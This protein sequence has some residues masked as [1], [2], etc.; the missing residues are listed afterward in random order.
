MRGF[1][2]ETGL[3]QRSIMLSTKLRAASMA[4][5]VA[6]L[7][8]NSSDV[9]PSAPADPAR[10]PGATPRDF[11]ASHTNDSVGAPSFVWLSRSDWP[12]FQ[13][14]EIAAKEILTAVAP[15]FK[16]KSSTTATLQ[17]AVIHDSGRGPIIAKFAQRVE[18]VEVF[19]GGLNVVMS[20]G[21]EPVAASGLVA[22]N[23]SRSKAG[24]QSDAPSAL[25]IAHQ[26]LTGQKASFSQLDEQGDYQRFGSSS[27]SFPLAQPAR[28]KRVYFPSKGGL[29]AG[30]FTELL[31]ANGVSHT[32][33]VSATT[34]KILFSNDLVKYDAYSYRVW[35]D[36]TTK[37]PMDGPQ[38]ND[39]VPLVVPARS[40]FKATFVP[41][42]VVTLQNFPFSKNDPWLPA[43]AT[44]TV[45]NNVRA[46]SD[47]GQPNG[48]SPSGGDTI[49]Q[50]TSAATFDYSYDTA[51]TSAGSTPEAVKAAVTQM[52][53]TTNFLHDWFYDSGFDEKSGNH[54]AN[55]LGR[56]G[57]Q[58]DPLLAETQDFS[59]RNNANA[60]TP[61][62]GASPRIQMYLFGGA[63]NAS[64]TVDAPAPNA[65]IKS[66]GTAGQFGKDS[67]DLSGPVVIVSDGGG[68]DAADA[69]ENINS[70][71]AGKIALVHRG[72]CSF[73]QKA[74]K[75]QAAGGVGI[76]IVN[77]A[78]SASPA[79]PPFMGGTAL[80]VT[81]PAVSLNLADGQALESAAAGAVT[82][83][84]KRDPSKDI[85]GALD[86]QIVSHEWGHVLSNRLVGDGS[87]LDT[88]MAGGLGEGWAD[89]LAQLITVR[90]DDA[91][92]ASNANWNGVYPSATYAT[93][94][95]SEFYFGI[96]RV[97]YSTDLTKDPLTFKH[98]AD[99]TPLPATAPISFGEDG[100]SNSE[101]HNTGEVW[102]TMLWEC[103]ASLLRD[104]RFT[105]QQAQDRMKS[106]LVASL[107]LT[108]PS[109]TMLEA[110]DAVLAAAYANDPKDFDLFWKAFA[111][112]G[113]GVG[114]VA[115]PRDALDNNPVK[116]S[117][118][119]GN[120]ASLVSL[121]VK[122]DVITC[123][124][125]GILDEGELGT[126]VVTIRNSGAGTLSETTAKLSSKS[127]KV[128]F[129]DQ[130]IVKFEPFKPF[131]QKTALVKAY[132]DGVADK[133]PLII[134]IAVDDPT[135]VVGGSLAIPLPVQHGV[136]EVADSATTDD[137]ET[138]STAW[139]VTGED[140]FGTSVQWA[141]ILTGTNHSWFIPN[142]GEPADH[143]LTSP[144]FEVT[145]TTFTLAWKHRWAFE[146]SEK[147]MKD[148]D[149]G[150]VEI[151]LDNGKTWVDLSKYAKM[152]YNVTLEDDPETTMVLKG[153]KAYGNE[154]P[155]YPDAWVDSKITVTLP[156]AAATVKLRFRHG[157]DD[158]SASDG[159]EIDDLSVTDLNNKPFWSFV[160]QRDQCDPAGPTAIAPPG[161][162]ATPKQIVRLVG[163]GTHP[164]NLP[165]GF[166]WS[167]LAGPPVFLSGRTTADLAF[168][169]PDTK[170]AVTIKLALRAN[171]G[172][173]LSAPVTVDVLVNPAG[174]FP[175]DDGG[176][177]CKVVSSRSS[178]SSRAL[179]GA[180]LAALAL[181]L[182]RRRRRR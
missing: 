83:T 2:A 136:D 10:A 177:G 81:I 49:A 8:C 42:N 172:A 134:D 30:W 179:W 173:L 94:G 141:R 77:V 5:L 22:T 153:R 178:S 43:A 157:A 164:K 76:I 20:R 120:A 41:S 11:T 159:W 46:Y 107:K 126:I 132:V 162:S 128:S 102:A 64:L 66:V 60:S 98:I 140:Q 101:V 59:G 123:D 53:Y 31:L 21:F 145:D 32:Y 119:V 149:G 176:C 142:A 118:E 131:E 27:S 113:A 47:V 3:C 116:E 45:G 133:E 34:G 129:P 37:L 16:L 44:T 88:N 171:D 71:L 63:T 35:A 50:T 38:G 106:Y 62:D 125:D 154:S 150:V 146:S 130:G 6:F 109:P 36:P 17:A 169:A 108:P 56:G 92:V 163:T 144:A 82:I 111:K 110:R 19:R 7:G 127:P 18:G 84:M 95:D 72:N 160:P 80:D 175:G 12:K 97:P 78:T 9:A 57:K 148:F 89:F 147:D 143:Q 155:G 100:S 67:F 99:G 105:F 1:T 182:V 54:Q 161:Q 139:V 29:E 167:Q 51:S 85:D 170:Q 137:V 181:V 158:N 39:A 152:D 112:R 180:G 65:G 174:A 4:A 114:A 55:N 48:Y 168:E 70:S 93:G 73:V 52:F 25:A 151:T 124:R 33:V 90:P 138:T 74:Q 58:S 24:F 103:Y 86:D 91:Q 122:D 23:V 13:T 26:R 121:S 40:G 117:F 96:R 87:G 104:S 165:L 69:C 79:A 28:A 156:S 75:V 15:T 135:M 14:A 115:P 61:P 166:Y 68:A